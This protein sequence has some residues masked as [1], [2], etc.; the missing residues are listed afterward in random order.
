MSK[1]P[2]GQAREG[3]RRSTSVYISSDSGTGACAASRLM[4]LSSDAGLV[5]AHAAVDAVH[6]VHHRGGGGSPARGRR[7]TAPRWMAVPMMASSRTHPAARRTC[8]LRRAKSKRRWWGP[9]RQ[10]HGGGAAEAALCQGVAGCFGGAL[11]CRGGAQH[12]PT[13]ATKLQV[14][15]PF[16]G[17][18]WCAF[19]SRCFSRE[20]LPG[21]PPRQRAA[22]ALRLVTV[23]PTQAP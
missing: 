8:V 15:R 18:G 19:A 3:Q 17:D 20:A 1:A 4:R 12:R 21:R 11:R 9:K 10:K 23:G 14:H 22:P 13:R 5:R 7:P 6:L 2:C 16:G